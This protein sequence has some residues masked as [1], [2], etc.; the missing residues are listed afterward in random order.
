[1]KFKGKIRLLKQQNIT[2]YFVL[3]YSYTNLDNSA[4]LLGK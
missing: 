2:K 3:L 1:M 4:I